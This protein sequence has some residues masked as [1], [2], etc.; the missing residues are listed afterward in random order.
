MKKI[1]Q[2][3]VIQ[4]LMSENIW[5][6]SPKT[7][8]AAYQKLLK[9]P[10][11]D[12]FFPYLENR[13]ITRAIVLMGPRRVGKTVLL[14]HAI[15]RLIEKGVNP[16]TICYVSVDQPLYNGLSLEDFL[17]TFREAT[18]IDYKK[19]ECFVFFDEIQYLKNWEN[20]LKVLVDKYPNV[21]CI[22]SGSAAAALRIKSLESGAGRF[23][24]FLLP[25]L[26]FYE[27][28]FLLKKTSLVDARASDDGFFEA[29][30][31]GSIAELNKNF[32]N[33]LNFGGY[34]EVALSKEIQ[35]NPGQF[36]K[37]DIIDKV[38]LRDLPSLYGIKDIQE[39]NYLFTTLAFN[40]A[41]EVSLEQLA[42]GSGIAKNTIKKYIE[43]LEAAFLIK[44]VHRVDRNARRLKRA[45]T[46]KVYLTN[47][48]MRAA[49]F[50]IVDQK[51]DAIGQLVE[52][53]VYSQ[54]FHTDLFLHY[55]RWSKGEVDIVALSPG[56]KVN[57]AIEVKWSDR[58][59]GHPQDLKSLITFCHEHNL[60][61]AMVISRSAYAV[62]KYQNVSLNF[63]PASLYCYFLGYN[64]IHHRQLLEGLSLAKD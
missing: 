9:R 4:R 11:L 6:E 42:R 37:S 1:P 43:Y 29:V 24:N 47:P 39:L 45:T 62:K 58:F 20:H 31:S 17:E 36:V 49:L 48:S 40:T 25:P 61:S 2:N 3:Q 51:D 22:V 28:M 59:A 10:Y 46:L 15:D 55:A 35:R 14:H 56:Q 16:D 30:H 52:T 63:I 38:L 64:V 54:L 12:I 13:R 34:P 44:T 41:D 26:T 18:G 7:I 57:F 50:D 23:S 27:Y 60:P 8:P 21:K 53:A 19:Q 5:W 33:Y 32:I